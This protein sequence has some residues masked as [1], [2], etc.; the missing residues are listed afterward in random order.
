MYETVKKNDYV[1]TCEKLLESSNSITG[2]EGKNDKGDIKTDSEFDSPV[3]YNMEKG[4][5]LS[6][7][8]DL[9]DQHLMIILL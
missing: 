8:M 2:A 4:W 1:D 7:E 6:E 9:S 3:N 5:F